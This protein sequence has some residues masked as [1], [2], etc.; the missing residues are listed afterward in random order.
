MTTRVHEYLY[1][2]EVFRQRA[3]KKF[4]DNDPN[5]R[6][7]LD[8]VS[9]LLLAFT[10]PLSDRNLAHV[11]NGQ[12]VADLIVSFTRTHFIIAEHLTCSELVEAAT[13]LRKQIELLSR[14]YELQE[15]DLQALI[16]RTPNLKRLET[17]V[18]RLYGE[19]SE[20]A[21]SS[22]PEKLQLL[23]R[24]KIE[25]GTV[26]V[27]YPQYEENSLV[28]LQHVAMSVFEFVVWMS[29]FWSN[30]FDDLDLDS[31]AP[32]LEAS[33]NAHHELYKNAITAEIL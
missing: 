12:Y 33:I 16:K 11:P 10:L 31:L 24:I 20:I 30:S 32:L 13:L 21:H 8:S 25:Q 28:T 19:Y 26:T 5:V 18:R 17:N 9:E 14:L 4:F 23:G 29:G 6:I 27:L 3:Q 2:R 15:T 22:N 1:S 7:L